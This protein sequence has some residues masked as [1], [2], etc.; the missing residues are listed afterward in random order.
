MKK[1]SL[2]LAVFALSALALTACFP[3]TPLPPSS[4]IPTG[5]ALPGEQQGPPVPNTTPE[6]QTAVT[7]QAL[8]GPNNQFVRLSDVTSMV[9]NTTDTGALGTVTGVILGRPVPATSPA[10]DGSSENPNAVSDSVKAPEIEYVVVNNLA[11]ATT[12]PS[13]SVLVPWAAFDF[14]QFAMNNNG[15]PGIA[16]TLDM[17]RAAFLDAPAFNMDQLMAN[18]TSSQPWDSLYTSYWSGL[19]VNIPMTGANGMAT[20][21]DSSNAVL[22]Q[23][24]FGSFALTGADN[25]Q[26]GT[27][28]DFL[29]NINTGVLSYA[30]VTSDLTNNQYLVPINNLQWKTTNA[31]DTTQ[32]S[33]DLGK[34]MAKFPSDAFSSAPMME[35]YNAFNLSQP[36]WQQKIDQYW[37]NQLLNNNTNP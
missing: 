14:S 4:A 21:S 28:D 15:Q 33:T 6:G 7:P 17:R 13:E 2:I 8:S 32:L 5:T 25:Q 22:V 18:T 23:D 27:I 20:P 16:L 10:A 9:V 37:N 3:A 1:L 26:I 29:V 24:Q 30:L 36:D 11:N 34:F 12:N 19:G 35:S 31:S